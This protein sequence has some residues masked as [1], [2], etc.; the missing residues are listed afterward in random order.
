LNA[1]KGKTEEQYIEWLNSEIAGSKKALEDKLGISVKT[2]AYPYGLH[3]EVVRKV[4]MD[5]GYEAGFTVYGQHM[6]FNA[7]PAMLGRYAIGSVHKEIFKAATGFKG[8]G[9]AD[10]PAI[11]VIPASATM[12]TSP[13]EGET[14]GDPQPEIKANLA[15]LGELDPKSVSMRLSG[16]GIVPATYD[17]KTKTISYKPT[18]KL[19][20]PEVTVIVAGS[21]KG[22]RKVETRWSFKFD[23]AATTPVGEAKP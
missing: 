20:S 18:Q 21:V 8:G 23:P 2:I 15:T 10:A 16:F 19:K 5:S 11:T 4:V 14:V 9:G 17:E 3:N 1:R 7:D 12:L 6:S 22:G 13:M